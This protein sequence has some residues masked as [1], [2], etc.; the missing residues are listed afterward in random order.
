M[1]RDEW[2]WVGAEARLRTYEV[3]AL[4]AVLDQTL[5]NE[6]GLGVEVREEEA[7]LNQMALNGSPVKTV[8]VSETFHER[9]MKVNL[10]GSGFFGGPWCVSVEMFEGQKLT[11]ALNLQSLYSGK[12][13]A[14]SL[15]PV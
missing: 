4:C 5:R 11:P 10:F 3:Y 1:A 2:E 9:Q 15:V 7:T 6:V 8:M 13:S 14:N 12:R